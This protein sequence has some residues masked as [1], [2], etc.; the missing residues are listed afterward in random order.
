MSQRLHIGFRFN[1]NACKLGCHFAACCTKCTTNPQ[2][3][4]LS[5][6]WALIHPTTVCIENCLHCTVIA[7]F[8]ISGCVD[9]PM[10]CRSWKLVIYRSVVTITAVVVAAAAAAVAVLCRFILG[11]GQ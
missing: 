11:V 6:V 10:S 2:L 1:F 3:I 4:E 7:L 9:T 8:T 5:G